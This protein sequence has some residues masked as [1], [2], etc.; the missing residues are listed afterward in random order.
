MKSPVDTDLL[1]REFHI[2]FRRPFLFL[3]AAL[4]IW[5]L[6]RAVSWR[7]LAKRCV[8]SV[9]D[10]HCGLCSLKWPY[11]HSW[12]DTVTCVCISGIADYW[13]ASVRW[14]EHWK[15]FTMSTTELSESLWVFLIIQIE[16]W[17]ENSKCNS[18]YIYNKFRAVKQLF[19]YLINYMI[20]W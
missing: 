14:A 15:W 2:Q 19:F 11:F 6:C 7:N 3:C 10:Q 5:Q 17:W 12:S 4:L 13:L 1:Q 8:P 20:C 9:I 18:L 16:F